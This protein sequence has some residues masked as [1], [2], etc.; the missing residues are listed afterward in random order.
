VFIFQVVHGCSGMLIT[1]YTQEQIQ[2]TKMGQLEMTKKVFKDILDDPSEPHKVSIS[3]II[4]FGQN[5]YLTNINRR[6]KMYFR[7]KI[8]DENLSG[9]NY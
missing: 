7:K 5:V 8:T 6:T 4:N 1:C 3:R 2:E 9:N